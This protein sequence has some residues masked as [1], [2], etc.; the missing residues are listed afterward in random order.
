MRVWIEIVVG[1]QECRV[2]KRQSVVATAEWKVPTNLEVSSPCN[3]GLEYQCTYL[4]M[5]LGRYIPGK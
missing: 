4:G 1:R 2:L 5:Y 3:S